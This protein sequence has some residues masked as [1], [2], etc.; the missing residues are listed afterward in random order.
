MGDYE[1]G[2]GRD[3]DTTRNGGVYGVSFERVNQ[4]KPGESRLTAELSY[5]V[6]THQGGSKRRGV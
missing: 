4:G 5:Y 2:G 6:I 1:I 3:K